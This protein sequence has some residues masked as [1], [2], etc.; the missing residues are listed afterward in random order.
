MLEDRRMTPE[1]LY[2]A[3]AGQT[4]IAEGDLADVARA[5]RVHLDTGEPVPIAVLDARTSAPVDLDL[6]GTPD[7]AADRAEAMLAAQTA[8]A[9]RSARGRPRLGVVAR[10]VTLLPR[11]WDWL[12]AQRGGA[13][14]TLRKLVD[15]ARKQGRANERTQRLQDVTYRFLS[16]VAGDLP[17][18]EETARALY[19]WDLE[20]L[21][22]LIAD[23]PPDVREH[24]LR[25]L[26]R[27][28]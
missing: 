17:G 10:E 9:E 18:F 23:W 1:P 7:E 19:A 12:N 24:T 20:R 26:R 14:V 15:A 3:F 2:I 25:L 28:E 5:V 21:E 4:R 8:A 6:R 27:E 11:H 16:A 22:A 13:S